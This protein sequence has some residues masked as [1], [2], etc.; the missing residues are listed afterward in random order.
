MNE[1][2]LPLQPQNNHLVTISLREAQR[3]D[4][5]LI[6]DIPARFEYPVIYVALEW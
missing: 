4:F 2:M 5:K 3:R 6:A 1:S